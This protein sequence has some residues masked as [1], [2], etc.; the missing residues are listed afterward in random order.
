MQNTVVLA[1]EEMLTT[2]E[3]AVLDSIKS[4]RAVCDGCG[5]VATTGQA[6]IFRDNRPTER[7]TEPLIGFH[8]AI[9]R[10]AGTSSNAPAA[11]HG[12]GRP[13]VA[14]LLGGLPTHVGQGIVTTPRPKAHGAAFWPPQTSN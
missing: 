9:T 12:C 7:I 5:H 8:Y 2:E 4:V 10:G 11:R 6:D 14:E 3:D 13:A 1:H